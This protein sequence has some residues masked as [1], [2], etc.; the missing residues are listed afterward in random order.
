MVV[1]FELYAEQGTSV[2]VV[3]GNATANLPA[4]SNA[5]TSDENESERER[6]GMVFAWISAFCYLCSR[7]PQI[8]RNVCDNDSWWLSLTLRL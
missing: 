4:T 6:A 7:I 8:W 3:S 5:Q 2:G 1:I